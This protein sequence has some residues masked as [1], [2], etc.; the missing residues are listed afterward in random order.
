[1]SDDDLIDASEI[2]EEAKKFLEGDLGKT[3]VARAQSLTE[4]ALMQ[5][6]NVD[7]HDAKAIM[8]LQNQIAFGES[9]EGWLKDLIH[10]GEN[11]FEVWKQNNDG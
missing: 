11:A 3:L 8:K 7:P 1:M 10:I 4:A 2:G 6:R 5:F 9:F